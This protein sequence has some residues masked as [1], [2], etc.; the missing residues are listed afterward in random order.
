MFFGLGHWSDRYVLFFLLSLLP[1]GFWKL[2]EIV[3]WFFSHL[4][5]H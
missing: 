1:L 4:R 5:W 2:L 3:F